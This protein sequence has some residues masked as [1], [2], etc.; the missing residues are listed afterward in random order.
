VI[1]AG[2]I[3]SSRRAPSLLRSETLKH[4]AGNVPAML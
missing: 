1:G 3:G 2:P 4:P